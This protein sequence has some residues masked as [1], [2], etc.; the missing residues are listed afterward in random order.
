MHNEL[1]SIGST[2]DAQLIVKI[3]ETQPESQS[4]SKID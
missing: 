4:V 3:L 1:K 2:E